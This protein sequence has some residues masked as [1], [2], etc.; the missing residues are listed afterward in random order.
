MTCDI[1]AFSIAEGKSAS[2][3]GICF[4]G[5][6][7]HA[8]PMESGLPSYR[9]TP[10]LYRLTPP[11]YPHS[12]RKSRAFSLPEAKPHT[13][14][15]DDAKK[16]LVRLAADSGAPASVCAETT[17]ELPAEDIAV[18]LLAAYETARV[19]IDRPATQ[20]GPEAY[21]TPQPG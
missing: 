10:H 14:N 20:E 11:R 16:S 6:K 13:R 19:I 17:G 8:R 3:F 7:S 9:S 1:K 5:R 21:T 15:K 12:I 4:L 18:N 2:I